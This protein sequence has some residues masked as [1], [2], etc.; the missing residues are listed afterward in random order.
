MKALFS[1]PFLL[2]SVRSMAEVAVVVAA[3]LFGTVRVLRHP[4]G[5]GRLKQIFSSRGARVSFGV[6]LFFLLIALLDSIRLPVYEI[7]A[8]ERRIVKTE[9]LLE[10]LY[11]PAREE[12]LS[13]PLATVT[14]EGYR[15]R[16]LKG[17]HILGTD[18]NGNDVLLQAL[19]G[20]RTALIIGGLTVVIVIP[21][22][23]LF[24]VLAGYF[25]GR[26]DDL[27]TYVFSTI[28]SVP[29]ILLLICLMKL[30]GQ[31]LTQLCIAMGITTWVGLCRVVR[32]ETLKLREL[33]F[34]QAAR[35]L[36]AGA[37]SILRRHIIPNVM[38][39]VL[40]TAILRFSG[41]VLSEAILSYL[42][43]GVEPGT[44]SW[45]AMIDQARNDLARDPV[46]WW[47]VTAAG[48]ML[49][50]LILAANVFGD[51]VRDVLDPRLQGRRV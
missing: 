44:G 24:G 32:G 17:R 41:L 22:G 31:G 36:G 27:I 43:I 3:L 50:I 40:I 19:K 13:A 30:M 25:G 35:A 42:G 20:V 16:P 4:V 39:I 21:L 51:R 47:S 26:V 5:R 34:V 18:L 46:V 33:P 11:H 1:N 15:S 2:D 48:T 37:F 23:I 49:F 38:H 14:L 12:T 6:L 9:T 29:E 10:K 8:G 45:G 7:R 28:E